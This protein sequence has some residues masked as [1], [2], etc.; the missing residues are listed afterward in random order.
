[1]STV[2]EKPTPKAA[3]KPASQPVSKITKMPAPKVTAKSVKHR[4]DAKKGNATNAPKT[5]NKQKK[6]KVIRDSF[7]M[8]ESEYKLIATIKKRC[9]AKGLAVKKSEV[10]RAAISYF[11]NQSDDYIKATVGALVVIKTGRPPKERK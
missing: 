5:I 8:P 6:D 7:T 11:A 4:E 3:V 10:L 2:S 9:I 1:M